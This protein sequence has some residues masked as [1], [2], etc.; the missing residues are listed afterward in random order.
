MKTIVRK[1][2]IAAAIAAVC[3]A[4]AAFGDA[5]QRTVHFEDL[6]LNTKAGAVRL[7]ERI[8]A[9]AEAVCDGVGDDAAFKVCVRQAVL[10]GVKDVNE[11]RLTQEYEAE[12]GAA[13]PI[14]IAVLR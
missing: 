3:L 1:R 10:A 8:L 14:E 7:F 11:P 5:P 13:K 4:A 12:M 2:N 9:A 6:N